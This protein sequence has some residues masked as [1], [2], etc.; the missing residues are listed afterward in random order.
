MGVPAMFVLFDDLGK[1]YLRRYKGYETLPWCQDACAF[2]IE[3]EDEAGAVIER[4][5]FDEA[6]RDEVRTN[7]HRR[8]GARTDSAGVIARRVRQAVGEAISG[9]A[10]TAPD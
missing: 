10:R 6:S 5:I 2:L 8:F 7:F 9:E 4:A 1:Q 3:R